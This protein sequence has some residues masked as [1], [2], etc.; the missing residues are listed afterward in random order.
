MSIIKSAALDEQTSR[1]AD[2]LP[3]FSHFVRECLL[4]H[5]VNM[6]AASCD[7]TRWAQTLSRSQN[8]FQT[9]R[10]NPATQP[11]CFVCWPYGPPP[12]EAVKKFQNGESDLNYLDHEAR[13]YNTHLIDL[14]GNS[15]QSKRKPKSDRKSTLLERFK[16]LFTQ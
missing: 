4:R 15:V 1:I 7:R 11:S 3:N 5:A 9:D 2:N 6:N 16:Q 10:C 14:K 12:L 8:Q 13:K